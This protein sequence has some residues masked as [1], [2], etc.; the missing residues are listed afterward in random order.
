MQAASLGEHLTT[1]LRGPHQLAAEQLPH[2]L[3]LLH[4]HHLL[5][6]RPG[7]LSDL[8]GPMLRQVQQADVPSGPVIMT[9]FIASMTTASNSCR[10]DILQTSLN[11]DLDSLGCIGLMHAWAP[12]DLPD[13]GIV[14]SAAV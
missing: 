7:L 3:S 12:T 4:L 10:S 8:S 6:R 1:I 2:E 13:L 9:Y 14:Q 11:A 5:W